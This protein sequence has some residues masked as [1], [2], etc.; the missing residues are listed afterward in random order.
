MVL[1]HQ[2]LILVPVLP[3]TLVLNLVRN[4]DLNLDLI[5]DLNLDLILDLNQ[6]PVHL[7]NSLNTVL[8]L[9]LWAHL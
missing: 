6:N 4:P 2:D 9:V 1:L 3:Q 8:L 5:L 7:P